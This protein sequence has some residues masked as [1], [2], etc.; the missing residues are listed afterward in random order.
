MLKW[1][2]FRSGVLFGMLCFA[3]DAADFAIGGG[4][5]PAS[6][7]AR[8]DPNGRDARPK[9]GGTL[10]LNAGLEFV[11]C[12]GAAIGIEVPVAVH[13]SWSSDVFARGGYAGLYTERLTAVLTPGVRVRL[14]SERRLTAWVSFGAGLA[15]IRRSGTTSLLLRG[16][17]ASDFQSDSGSR[18]CGTESR[19]WLCV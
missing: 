10:L 18:R 17:W 6:G 13:G 15:M 2:I 8:T 11:Q 1:M 3:T 5:G 16:A 9:I 12:K 7:N 19:R 14:A 4:A